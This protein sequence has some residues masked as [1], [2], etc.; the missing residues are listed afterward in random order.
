MLA[1]Q[2]IPLVRPVPSE[3]GVEGDVRPDGRTLDQ[4]RPMHLRTGVVSCASGSAMLEMAHTKVLCSVF[5]PH[6]LDGRDF[7]EEGQ[8][9]CTV[10]FASFARRSRERA[11]P[12]GTAEERT[13]SLELAA[14]LS[15][16]VQLHLLPKSSIAVH[17]L[18]LQDDGG[19][20]PAAISCASLALADASIVLYDLVAACGCSLRDERVAL[21]ASSSELAGATGRLVLACMP[22]VHQL[23]LVRQE[24]AVTTERLTEA[25]GLAL[26]GCALLRREMVAALEASA[27]ADDEQQAGEAA[28]ETAGEARRANKRARTARIVGGDAT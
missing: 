3:A 18:V 12:G 10:R 8:L 21:D 23:T 17:A 26:S 27:P 25:V 28:G 22:S 24:G 1:L 16:S 20:L 2:S 7:L 4:L 13:L 5:G 9:E 19:A 6:A 11:A 14:A 15:A